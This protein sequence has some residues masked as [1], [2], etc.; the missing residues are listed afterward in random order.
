M[1]DQVDN[2]FDNFDT[3][4]VSLMEGLEEHL[5]DV[6]IGV[7]DEMRDYIASELRDSQSE[8]ERLRKLLQERDEQMHQMGEAMDKQ[9]QEI[10]QL[11]F[12]VVGLQ[13]K[14]EAAQKK[15]HFEPEK[16]EEV[17]AVPVIWSK[18]NQHLFKKAT[19]TINRALRD[20]KPGSKVNPIDCDE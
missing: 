8:V 11:R 18:K 17:K 16:K 12:E 20:L 14:L 9:M 19:L 1:A 4:I 13:N 3:K 10:T 15:V 2:I 6:A 5:R 7:Q